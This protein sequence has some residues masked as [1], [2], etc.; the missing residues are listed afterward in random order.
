MAKALVTGANGFV[1][2]Q[3]VRALNARGDAVTCLVRRTSSLE[4]IDGLKVDLAYG[5]VTDRS[6]V[7]SA[8]AGKE[9]VYHVAGCTRTIRVDDFY[10]V[11]GHGTGHV[12]WACTRQTTPPVV[13]I[14]SSLAA[15]GPAVG[16]RDGRMRT[17]TDRPQPVSHYGRSKRSGERVAERFAGRLPITVVRPPIIF[18]ERDRIGLDMFR[19]VDRLRT[20]VVPGLARYRMS[21]I[22]VA[23]L[24][25]MLILAAHGGRRLPAP[26]DSGAPPGQGYYFAACDEHPAYCDLGQMI[27]RA[28]G[29]RHI[30]NVH[31]IAL[32]IWILAGANETAGRALGRPLYLN[33]DKA[34]EVTAG[35]WVCSPQRAIDELGFAVAAPLAERLRRTG[36]WYRQKGWL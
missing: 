34:R 14:V 3:L 24:A 20:H 8:I 30:C 28:L 16:G 35:S 7:R 11:N 2:S 21:L 9:I 6:S 25:Q 31:V 23:D 36:E 33:L 19:M 17:E 18:G 26:E 32:L 27:G 22:H 10:R 5:D 12:L 13:V 15:A 1:G 29:H 4:M